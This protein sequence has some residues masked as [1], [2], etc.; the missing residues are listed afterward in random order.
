[1]AF[2]LLSSNQRNIMDA[3]NPNQGVFDSTYKNTLWS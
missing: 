3:I 2:I 1:M